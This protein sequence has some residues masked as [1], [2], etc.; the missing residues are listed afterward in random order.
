MHI[1]FCAKKCGYC[2][3]YSL[4]R[5]E[6]LM[7]DY[8]KALI[9]QM[10]AF[11][12][13]CSG[14]TVDSVYIGGGTPSILPH[15]LIADILSKV[16]RFYRLWGKAEIT[17]EANPSTVNAVSM[18]AYRSS[19]IN[20]ISFGVQSSSNPMLQKLGRLHRFEEAVASILLAKEEGFDN[21]SAD[22]M[23]ALPGQ[24]VADFLSDVNALT[25]L[26][27]VHLSV[28]G[29]KIEE[30]TPFGRQKDLALPAEEEQC[31]MYLEGVELLK[32]KGFLQ[33][34][35]SNFAKRGYESRHNMKY[36]TRKEYLGF[37]PAAH[38]FLNGVRFCFPRDLQKYIDTVDFSPCVGVYSD[39]YRVTGRE[40]WE[41]EVMLSL[42]TRDGCALETLHAVA[43]SR[44]ALETYIKL[45]TDNKYARIENGRLSLTPKGM[46]LSNTI[47]SD[48]LVK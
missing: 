17:L 11:S 31:A 37:G 14:K 38:S 30:N 24:T 36:W 40:E 48:L 8:V 27:V 39:T 45:I 35:I 10:E 32:E 4:E 13:T 34:E 41:E 47:I 21:I 3:F 16:D 26:P 19:G 18:R 42:R 23:Y 1:P 5:R 7:S 44:E 43:E 33:Y 29:L 46:L 6:D 28:Y 15:R 9:R 25:S 12:D 20:R 22:L 2:D